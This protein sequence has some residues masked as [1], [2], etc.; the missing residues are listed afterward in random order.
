MQPP[1]QPKYLTSAAIKQISDWNPEE[2]PKK[3]DFILQIT[4]IEELAANGSKIREK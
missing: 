4:K 2:V 1:Q 3:I